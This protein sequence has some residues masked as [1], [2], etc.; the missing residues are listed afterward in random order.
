MIVGSMV[1]TIHLL[2]FCEPELAKPY[3][4]SVYVMGLSCGAVCFFRFFDKHKLLRVTI[5][6]STSVFIVIPY[7]H[8]FLYKY[9]GTNMSHLPVYVTPFIQGGI[10]T[11]GMIVYLN[12]FPE[13]QLGSTWHYSQHL[14]SHNIWH[15]AVICSALVGWY[16]IYESWKTLVLEEVC[17]VN[18]VLK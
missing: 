4:V 7:T 16:G 15:L 5:L 17:A 10:Y 8:S 1:P 11:L 6:G 3:I 2:F 18:K 12:R 14:S 9:W 13:K